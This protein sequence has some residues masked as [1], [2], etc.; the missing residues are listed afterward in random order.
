METLAQIE[1]AIL[2]LSATE[3]EELILS[4]L[5]KIW[6]D[7]GKDETFFENVKQLVDSEAER[8]YKEEYMDHI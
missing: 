6:K 1:K 5:P 8:R 3:Q 7:L 2:E 4:V